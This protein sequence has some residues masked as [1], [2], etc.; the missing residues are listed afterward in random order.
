MSEVRD[1]VLGLIAEV[2]CMDAGE[3]DDGVLLSEYGINSIDMIDVVVKVEEKYKIRLDPDKMR[4]LTAR[5]L[6]DNVES[7]VPAGH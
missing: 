7:V 1:H 4:N 5:R 3:I 6:I 2:L